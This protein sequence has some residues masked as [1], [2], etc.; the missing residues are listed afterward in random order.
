MAS[1]VQEY[2]SRLSS[3]TPKSNCYCLMQLWRLGIAKDA[4]QSPTKFCRFVVLEVQQESS[5]ATVRNENLA[6]S[7]CLD[8]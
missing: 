3:S 6:L 1:L 4:M 5:S 7:C 8:C 2:L